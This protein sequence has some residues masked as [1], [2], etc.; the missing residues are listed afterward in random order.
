MTLPALRAPTKHGEILA[1]PALDRV[2]EIVERNRRLLA[3]YSLPL[4]NLT[5]AECRQLARRELSTLSQD[6]HRAA[7]ESVKPISGDLWLVAGHQPELFHPGVW[8]KNFAMHQL[9]KQLGSASLN[10]VI[11]TDTAKSALLH[12]PAGERLA[13]LPIDRAAPEMPY[14]ERAVL[15]EATFASVP[16]RFAE[17]SAS[18]EFDPMLVNF[19]RDMPRSGLLG[20]RFARARRRIEQR[21]GVAQAEAPMSRACGSEAFATFAWAILTRLQEFHAFYNET[22]HAYRLAHGIR[23]KN[24]PVPDLAKEGEFLEI[25][26][27]AWKVGAS[28]RER[29]FAKPRGY[30]IQLR[31]GV[32][33]G[34][35]IPHRD[36]VATWRSLEAQGYKIRSRALTTTMFLRLFVAD[37]FIHGIGG[38]IYDALT[39]HIIQRFFGVTPPAFLILS[40]TL[41]LPLP[42]FPDAVERRRRWHRVLRELTYQPERSLP[43]SEEAVEKRRWIARDGRTHKERAERFYHIR[44][45]NSVMHPLLAQQFQQTRAALET[46]DHESRLHAVASRRDY[47]FCLYP[48]EMLRSFFLRNFV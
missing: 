46:A 33:T 18:W 38:G 32:E 11:D 30:S 7:A 5:F 10:L 19:W 41:H 28:R 2:G 40:A 25:P 48:E 15:D 47:A 16:E 1:A 17:L 6:Y 44:A 12:I 39:D 14:E 9:A 23:S 31:I 21:W 20:E 8:F 3:D 24:H 36:G 43:T 4:P 26:F 13:R 22:V 42:P 37:L 34:P 29:L 45:I 35:T 27:W